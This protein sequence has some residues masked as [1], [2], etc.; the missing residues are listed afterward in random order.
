MD[1]Y[2][3]PSLTVVFL[4]FS[5]YD[6]IYLAYNEDLEEYYFPHWS[7]H[8]YSEDKFKEY[9]AKF[10]VENTIGAYEWSLKGMKLLTSTDFG[11]RKVTK[12]NTIIHVLDRTER[13]TIEI[14]TAAL[15]KYSK[16]IGYDY[17]PFSGLTYFP[18]SY[19]SIV[20]YIPAHFTRSAEI[21]Y[22]TV[23]D[24]S[25]VVFW[26]AETNVIESMV[27]TDGTFSIDLVK[28]LEEHLEE[29]ANIDPR[30]L[31]IPGLQKRIVGFFDMMIICLE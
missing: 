15:M 29:T 26:N 4:L 27:K 24:D 1:I 14:P 28:D 30:E 17:L 13:L 6:N 11:D 21:V 7:K 12:E 2:Q 22:G 25:K 31:T 9:G 8:F 3:N 20:I 18:V 5:D 19:S 16:K 23:Y 10:A